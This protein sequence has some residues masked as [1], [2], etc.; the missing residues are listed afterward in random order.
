MI[1]ADRFCS[2]KPSTPDETCVA[3]AHAIPNS[4]PAVL[5]TYER[6]ARVTFL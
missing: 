6:T 2:S 1:R 3:A 4:L 5:D